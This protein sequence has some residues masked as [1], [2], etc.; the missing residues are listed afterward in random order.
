MVMVM[1]IVWCG[2]AW[3]G[4]VVLGWGG[5]GWGGLV[6]TMP[7]QC[8]TVSLQCYAVGNAQ[9]A[10]HRSDIAPRLDGWHRVPVTQLVILTVIRFRFSRVAASCGRGR[11]VVGMGGGRVR[12]SGASLG[13]GRGRGRWGWGW[14]GLDWAGWPGLVGQDCYLALARSAAHSTPHLGN[15]P[16]HPLH[17]CSLRQRHQNGRRWR[18]RQLL[19]LGLELGLGSRPGSE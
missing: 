19:L 12:R 6:R 14:S 3:M 17:R 1:V 13:W 8:P 15:R 10:S 5:L 7:I 11:H 9:K 4:R 18:R 2:V 16:R